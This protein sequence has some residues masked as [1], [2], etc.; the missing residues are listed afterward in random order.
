MLYKYNTLWLR[1]VQDTTA[2]LIYCDA[3]LPR[4]KPS[5][6]FKSFRPLNS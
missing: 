6:M 4:F 2:H 3:E 1:Q 5:G